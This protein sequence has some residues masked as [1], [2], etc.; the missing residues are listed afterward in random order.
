VNR[1]TGPGST[2]WLVRHDL[3]LAGRALRSAGRRKRRIVSSVLLGVVALLH[4]VGFFA[5]PAL[6]RLHNGSRPEILLVGSIALFGAFTLFLSKSITEATD[7]LFQRGDLD[8]LLSS[9]LPMRRVLISRLLAIAINAGFLPLLLVVPLVNGMVLRGEFAWVGLYAV[10]ICLSL[11]AA[12]LGAGLTFGLLATVGPRWTRVAARVLATLF[13]ATSFLATQSRLL[14]SEGMRARVWDALMPG[15]APSGPQWW[16]A[17]AALGDPWAILLLAVIAVAGMAVVSALLGQAYG[18]GVMSNLAL[19]RAARAGGVARRF[20]ASPFGALLRKEWRLL[21]RHPGLGAQ[22]FYQFFFL[23]PGAVA[24][25]DI[26]ANGWHSSAG[27]VFLTAMMTGRITKVVVT[28]PFEGD[29]AATLALSSPVAPARVV[30]A[31]LVVTAAALSAI[32][33]LPIVAIGL[34]L[35][36]AFPAALVASS[37]AAATRM[38]LAVAHPVQRRSP[39][40]ANRLQASTDGLLGVMLDIGWGLVGAALSL[41]I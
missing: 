9:P 5:A 38:W 2:L 24:L 25:R 29:Q 34:Q 23:L 41:V 27:V 10:Q 6:A 13:G 39:L 21:F 4:L 15:G 19:P 18:A 28:G 14:L 17:R 31:K 33:G 20:G 1:L 40:L 8:L 3:R 7:S 22:L 32:G 35:A 12:S 16:P 37:A 36:P 26:H 11:I 30:R